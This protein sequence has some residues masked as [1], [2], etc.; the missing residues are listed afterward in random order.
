MFPDIPLITVLIAG[1]TMII[2]EPL[3]YS[4]AFIAAWLPG[5]TG[6]EAIANAITG[7]YLF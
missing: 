7:K 2:N 5:T 3:T 4:K 6:G 1:R